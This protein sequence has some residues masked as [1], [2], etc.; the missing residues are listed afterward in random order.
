MNSLVE[1]K[2]QKQITPNYSQI[3]YANLLHRGILSW[4]QILLTEFT[5]T[6]FTST[7]CFR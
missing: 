6:V 2:I 7:N 5:D 3:N 4:L 1:S